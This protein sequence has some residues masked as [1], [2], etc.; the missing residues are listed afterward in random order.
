MSPSLGCPWN[1]EQV[2]TGVAGAPEPSH[3]GSLSHE[4]GDLVGATALKE[5]T[6]GL[7]ALW[8]TLHPPEGQSP[9]PHPH[10]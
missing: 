7:S 2:V 8:T 6:R 1:R 9:G 5:G 3:V 4:P 10:P